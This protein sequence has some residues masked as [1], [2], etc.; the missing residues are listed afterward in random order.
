M[1]RATTLRGLIGTVVAV[2]YFV[3]N[4]DAQTDYFVLGHHFTAGEFQL[5]LETTKGLV[6]A[7]AGG[8]IAAYITYRL[9]R[10]AK[11]REQNAALFNELIKPRVI[12]M[13]DINARVVA[14]AADY[15]QVLTLFEKRSNL[16]TV[17]EGSGLP[18]LVDL[19]RT[20]AQLKRH[21]H[22]RDSVETFQAALPDRIA[23]VMREADAKRYLIGEPQYAEVRRRLDVLAHDIRLEWDYMD[24]VK[25]PKIL[26]ELQS[27]HANPDAW[28]EKARE[29]SEGLMMTTQVVEAL[30][31]R[32]IERFLAVLSSEFETVVRTKGL[33]ML[34]IPANPIRSEMEAVERTSQSIDDLNESLLEGEIMEELRRQRGRYEG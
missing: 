25:A 17:R 5:L 16:T 27:N 21:G 4:A 32:R 18:E 24:S 22:A 7:V 8:S 1:S 20:N 33:S 23:A 3:S 34:S 13:N 29:V 28:R 14:L 12:A 2:A 15:L 26:A 31:R 30:S 6:L 19:E 11:D 9:N 10:N